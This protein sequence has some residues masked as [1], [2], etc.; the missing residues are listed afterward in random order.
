MAG[1]TQMAT[2][3]VGFLAEQQFRYKMYIGEYKS[4]YCR[5]RI[6]QSV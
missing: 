6:A 2:R 4:L 5:A 3:I 1:C